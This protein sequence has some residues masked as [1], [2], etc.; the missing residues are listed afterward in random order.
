MSSDVSQTVA[1]PPDGVEVR[2]RIDA[3]TGAGFGGRISYLHKLWH[4]GTEEF[5]EL[6]EDGQRREISEV[7]WGVHAQLHPVYQVEENSDWIGP[8]GTPP[9][10]EAR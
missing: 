1:A 8:G 4:N 7:E 9:K 5:Y 2:E 6:H 10:P 3:V